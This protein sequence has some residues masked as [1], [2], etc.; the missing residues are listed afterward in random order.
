M[1]IKR[2]YGQSWRHDADIIHEDE[3]IIFSALRHQHLARRQ[4]QIAQTDKYRQYWLTS[5]W[6]MYYCNKHHKSIHVVISA[7]R[8]GVCGERRTVG[9]RQRQQA[10][11]LE[12]RHDCYTEDVAVQWVLTVPGYPMTPCTPDDLGTLPSTRP[13][14]LTSRYKITHAFNTPPWCTWRPC[15]SCHLS[16][17]PPTRF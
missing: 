3:G 13:R 5:R 11:M 9:C 1:L 4:Q 10:C 12:E 15:S 17:L 8:G 2:N 16:S 14:C 7:F 6:G